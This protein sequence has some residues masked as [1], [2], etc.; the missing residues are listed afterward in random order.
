MRELLRYLWWLIH[1]PRGSK[2]I[3]WS[4]ADQAQF[5]ENARRMGL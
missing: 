4:A 1:Q 2:E 3:Y 5:R